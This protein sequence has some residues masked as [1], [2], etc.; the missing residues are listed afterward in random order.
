M[1]IAFAADHA[2]FELK[3]ELL[4]YV[5]TLGHTVVDLGTNSLEPVDY[6]DYAEALGIT[7]LAGKAQRGILICGSV[8]ARSSRRTSSKGFGPACATIPIPRTKASSMTTSTCW[9]WARA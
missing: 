7:V 2:G 1:K 5:R 9:C 4:E 3:Q 6:P 8:S